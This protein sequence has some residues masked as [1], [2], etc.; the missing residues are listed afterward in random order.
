MLFTSI[1]VKFSRDLEGV[2]FDIGMQ[3]VA[4]CDD[5][6]RKGGVVGLDFFPAIRA[7]PLDV[8]IAFVVHVLSPK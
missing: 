4:M 5:K 8:G 1:P 6:S 7:H 3:S 2:S